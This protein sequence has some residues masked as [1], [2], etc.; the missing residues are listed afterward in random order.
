M[1]SESQ[2]ADLGAPRAA[3]A[4]ARASRSR[5]R[6]SSTWRSRSPTTKGLEAVSI[7]RLARELR[8][9]AM[10]LY[11][12]FDT[13]DEL[14]ELMGDTVAA[15][16]ARARAARGLARRRWRRSRTHSR[17]TFLAPPVA[18]ADAAGASRAV[19]PEP[20]AP[21]RAVRAVGHRRSPSGVDPALLT[22]IVTAVD[23]YTVGFTLRELAGGRRGARRGRFSE[24]S[25]PE[26]PLPARERRV[27]AA[28]A[29][30][31]GGVRAAAARLRASA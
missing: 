26:R 24:A 23:D 13:R 5:G 22:G 14:L 12:Y 17:A 21:H 11:H 8:S 9:G 19:T 31:R 1:S 20:A 27:P 3:R 2:A 4:R 7:R 10:S 6:R 16:D 30:H 25:R 18:A 15:R 29:V 28:R